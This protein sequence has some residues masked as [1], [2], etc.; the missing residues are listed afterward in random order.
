MTLAIR[1]ALSVLSAALMVLSVPTFNLWPLMWIGLL[2][3]LPVA[4]AA[5][6]PRRAFLYGWFLGAVANTAAFYWMKGLLERFGHMP[7]I[8]AIPIM[9]LLTIYQGAEFGLWTWGVHRVA[10]RRPGVAMTWVAP[11]VMIA[12]ELLVPQIFPFYLAISQA[13]VPPVIQIADI[14]GPMGVSFMMVMVTGAL[15]EAGHDV[16][17]LRRTA[18]GERGSAQMRAYAQLVMRRLRIPAA[19]VTL[20]LGYGAL[21]LHQVDARRAAAPKARVG[22][23][24]ANVGISEKWDPGER[25][26]LLRLHQDLSDALTR[27]GAD[28]IVWPESSYP[29]AIERDLDRD[30]PPGDPRRIRGAG[31][32]PTLFGAITLAP[33]PRKGRLRYPFNTA[34]MLDQA[35]RIT[36]KFDKVFLL[37]FGEYI[38]FYDSIPWF[39]D[40]FPE[41]S[42]FNRGESP[43]SFPFRLRGRDFRLGPL[44]CYEDILPGFTRRTAALDPN[45][46]V[47]IT[48]DAWFGK[49]FEPYQ[50]LALAVFR[51]VENRLEMVR[52]V[53]TGV[54]AHIDAA[55]RVKAILPAVDPSDEPPPPPARMLVEAALLDRGGVYAHIGDAFAWACLL[56][57]AALV[58][59]IPRRSRPNKGG[60][61]TARPP[62]RRRR[63]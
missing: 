4:L 5:S 58:I 44:I 18:G 19:I 14:T 21:R 52:A 20:V 32:T 53:N 62:R 59:G 22:I 39:T 30:F 27:E 8:E 35:G 45:L 42:N 47:N 36:G 25:D 11:L 60:A 24:Q 54:S 3:A 13:F 29:Y 15:F 46:L 34:L 37:I 16:I 43:G 57:L 49:T 55:G 63:R 28:L 17:A 23:V 10:R 12:I 38:P 48:N 40:L 56:A 61:K 9:L 2:P 41:A 50:H 51:S 33:E 7:G 31:S 1:L 26:H 6:T